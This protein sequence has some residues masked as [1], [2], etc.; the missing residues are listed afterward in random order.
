MGRLAWGYQAVYSLI[1]PFP[2]RGVLDA[3]VEF[4]DDEQATPADGENAWLDD[5]QVVGCLL[6]TSDAADE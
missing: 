6:Y 3:T 1:A 2:Q 4:Q 5:G